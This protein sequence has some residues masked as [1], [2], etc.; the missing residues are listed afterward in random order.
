MAATFYCWANTALVIEF[1]CATREEPVVWPSNCP[2][3]RYRSPNLV[4]NMAPTLTFYLFIFP[5]VSLYIHFMHERENCCGLSQVVYFPLLVL[6]LLFLLLQD[7]KTALHLASSAGHSD[8]VAAL[9]LNGAD[10][11]AQDHVS[12]IQSES[13][14]FKSHC[15]K[16]LTEEA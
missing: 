5:K 3:W 10:V 7:G 9:I 6:I 11:A 4:W 1:M 8:T 2:N 16:S 12:K 13:S 14:I 15:F